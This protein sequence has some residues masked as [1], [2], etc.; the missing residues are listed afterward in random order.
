MILRDFLFLDT[1][2][3]S[4]YLSTLEGY[5]LDGSIEQTE[6]G[7]K[8]SGGK[9]DL[10]AVSADGKVAKKTETKKKLAVTDAAQF[11]LLY[12]NLEEQQALQYLDAFDAGIWNQLHRGEILEVQ[13]NIRLPRGL[14][15]TQDVANMS[16]LVAL[17]K[18]V[19]KDP[20]PDEQS[21]IAFEGFRAVG[22][23]IE[24]RP[25][26]LIFE[27]VSTSGFT[28]VAHLPKKYLRREISELQGEATIFGKIQRIIPKG[29]RLEVF[30][31]V[32]AL[33]G[34]ASLSREQ[35]RK[36]QKSATKSQITEEVKGPAIIMIPVA[37]YR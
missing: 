23:S 3:M 25:I 8:A 15:L 14:L 6:T 21:R 22:Q 33:T 20:F 7:E 32:P 18:I 13:A 2:T 28:F 35:R 9:F 19:G 36:M 17:M 24:D 26:P 31:L 5:V 30:S 11:Q 12:E 34:A 4:D 10:K 1:Q 16:S 29:E 37:V 27:T